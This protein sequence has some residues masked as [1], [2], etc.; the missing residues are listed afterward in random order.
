M[1]AKELRTFR[2]INP[3][4]NFETCE[5]YYDL[6]YSA[7]P[8]KIDPLTLEE[9]SRIKINDRKERALFPRNI[10]IFASVTSVTIIILI[11]SKY[12]FFIKLS[13][14]LDS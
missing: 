1:F 14:K 3:P 5:V 6:D 4:E 13:N 11:T 8:V 2:K 9:G 7:V 10:V 12:A